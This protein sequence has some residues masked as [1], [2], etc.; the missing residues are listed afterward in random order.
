MKIR[1]RSVSV[2][3]KCRR[4]RRATDKRDG[5]RISIRITIIDQNTRRARCTGITLVEPAVTISDCDRIFVDVRDRHRNELSVRQR[6]IGHLHNH[7][8]N[9]IRPGIRRRFVIRS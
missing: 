8:V 1:E 2:Q 9:I 5:E 3:R 4:V 6:S 7:F